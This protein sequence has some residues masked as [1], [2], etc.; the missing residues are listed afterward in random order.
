M[1]WNMEDIFIQRVLYCP[2]MPFPFDF[3]H[4]IQ[5]LM[6]IRDSKYRDTYE[7][8]KQI[9]DTTIDEFTN[10]EEITFEFSGGYS[11]TKKINN[12]QVLQLKDKIRT[13]ELTLIRR[14]QRIELSEATHADDELND[15]R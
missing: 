14:I 6:S 2:L 10:Q 7:I 4:V 15:E 9:R 3:E 8:W 1:P 13:D 5:Y 12:E 11:K